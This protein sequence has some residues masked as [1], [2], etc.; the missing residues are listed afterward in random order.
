M[1][2]RLHPVF[3]RVDALVEGWVDKVR[4]EV[5]S[6]L[7]D[8]H[9]TNKYHIEN[10]AYD[11]FIPFTDGGWDGT[12]YADL[13]AAWGSGPPTLI[14]PY[15]ARSL[16]DAREEWDRD[17]PWAPV[18]W[19]MAD[20]PIT[21]NLDLFTGTETMTAEDAAREKLRNDLREEFYNF[22]HEWM[23]EGGTYFYKVRALYYSADNRRNETGTDEVLFC[24]A[25]NT[26]FEYGRDK[27]NEW[28]WEETVKAKHLTEEVVERLA[29]EAFRALNDA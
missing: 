28:L 24:V 17:K 26:D 23:V 18:E 25:I 21:Y 8:V 12:G 16:K 5:E 14:E 13:S 20:E 9:F 11:G 3:E 7:H 19:L 4:E 10:E 27:G 22:E 15:I 29:D 1:T 2:Y 6:F